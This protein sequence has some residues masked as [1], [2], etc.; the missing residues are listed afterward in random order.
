M[1]RTRLK[2]HVLITRHHAA[3]KM[4]DPRFIMKA[5]TQAL[6]E[7]DAEAFKEILAAHLEVTNKESFYKRA[8]ISRRT[9]FRMLAPEGNPTLSNIARVVSAIADEA[10]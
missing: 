1:P 3:A 10:A 6:L 9:L 5:L 7:G 2:K 8:G 4:A